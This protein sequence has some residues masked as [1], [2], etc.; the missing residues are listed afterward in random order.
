[1]NG[2]DAVEIESTLAATEHQYL[3]FSRRFSPTELNADKDTFFKLEADTRLDIRT[4]FVFED[5][6]KK[7]IS[8]SMQTAG[9]HYGLSVPPGTASIRLGLRIQGPGMAKLG[10]LYLAE[11]R[12]RPREVLPTAQHLI[13]ANQYPSYDDLYRYGF[14]HARLRA[15]SKVGVVAEVL[16]ISSGPRVEYREFEGVDITQGDAAYFDQC[17]ASGQYRSILVHIIDQ[18]IWNVLRNHLDHTRV[19][20]WAHGAEIQPWWRRAFNHNTDALRDQARRASDARM[21]MWHEILTLHHPNLR[22]VFVSHKQAGEAL[23][24]LQLPAAEVDGIEVISNFINGDLFSYQEKDPALRHRVLSIRPFASHVYANDLTVAAIVRLSRE[25]FF[26]Q[27][28]FR[29][30]GDGVLFEKITAPLSDFSNVQ[31]E[32]AFLTQREIAALHRE[33]GVFLVPSRMDS[34][35]VSRDEAMASGLVPITNR[36]AAIPE[37]V[38][39]DCALLAEPEDAAGLAAALRY[40]HGNPAQFSRMSV[41]AAQRVRNQSGFAHTIAR[42]LA[43]FAG[44]PAALPGPQRCKRL[45]DEEASATRLA[46]YGDV[47]LNIMDGSAI[48]AASLAEVLAG[49]ENVR[50]SLLLKARIHRTT[51]ISRLLDMAPALQLIEPT[52]P[53]RTGLTPA[54]A[55]AQLVALDSRTPCHGFI[56]RG[57]DV[58][59]SAAQEKSLRARLWAYLTDIPQQAALIDASTRHRIETIIDASAYLLCQTPQMR[60]YLVNLFPQ[61]A[62]KAKL[63]PPMVPSQPCG[64]HAA[65]I[66]DAPF[67]FAY[68]GKF[69]PRWGICDLFAAQKNLYAAVPDAELHVFGDKIHKPV[70]DPSFYATVQERLSA[71]DGLQWHGAVARDELLR[72]LT[73][74]HACWAYRDPVFERETLELSTKVLEYASLGL[75][76]ILARSKIFEELLGYDYPLFATSVEEA[77]DH[78]LQLAQTPDFRKTAAARLEEVAARYTFASVRERLLQDGLIISGGKKVCN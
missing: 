30:I 20:I 38:D 4:V 72:L 48:W 55:V 13:V 10:N 61:A 31:V 52:I 25:P 21:A 41:A 75:P 65:A 35:G 29:I 44:N 12:G 33:Y 58:C 40:L 47:N 54:E 23:A 49:I 73:G 11:T 3:Y 64:G 22:I 57:L 16:R 19:V 43:Q 76:M 56:L 7:K 71:G 66:P 1:M 32:R 37:F 26:D 62:E 69:A 77:S 50:V 39:A 8:H 5:T 70:D 27:L 17:I 59:Y 53:E 2:D 34:Q 67:C 45:I 28:H 51:V 36:V 60:D 24:D 68:A 9:G 18:R 15:Y 46:L 42:E 63:L 74:M 14:V 78:L 6:K